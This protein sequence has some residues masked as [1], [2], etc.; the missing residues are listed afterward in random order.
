MIF[1]S[2]LGL[3]WNN[4]RLTMY[5]H[6]NFDSAIFVYKYKVLDQTGR[7][8]CLYTPG[9]QIYL[10]PRVTYDDLWQ[11]DPKVNASYASLAPWTTCANWHQSRFIRF[12]IIVF[13]SSI[14]DRQTDGR[15]TQSGA[16]EAQKRTG[17][18]SSSWY[19]GPCSTAH[20][21]NRPVHWAGLC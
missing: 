11:S 13:T 18:W 7:Q 14:T 9:L 8:W 15:A 19:T 3:S 20:R 17:A 1:T 21:S 4:F 6:S 16:A 12:Q 5:K 10:R 2:M